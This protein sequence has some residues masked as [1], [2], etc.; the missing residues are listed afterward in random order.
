MSPG[1][2]SSTGIRFWEDGLL[3]KYLRLCG[4][5]SVHSLNLLSSLYLLLHNLH[6]HVDRGAFLFLTN[7][8]ETLGGGSVEVTGDFSVPA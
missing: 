4:Q 6:C 5:L 1:Q 2:G 3:E 7:V 8:C